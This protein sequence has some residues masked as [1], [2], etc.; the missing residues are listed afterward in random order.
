ME[1]L[2]YNGENL[3]NLIKDKYVLLDFYADWCGPC[4]MLT[5]VLENINNIDIIKINVDNYPQLARE[6]GVM[7]IPT[8]FIKKN[9][10]ELYKNI[11]FIDANALQDVI[12]KKKN[13]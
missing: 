10:Q 11:G 9:N 8:I 13:D 5:N 6:Y 1:I 12:N 2:Y 3:E 4:K 7:S